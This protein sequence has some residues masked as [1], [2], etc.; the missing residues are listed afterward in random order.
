MKAGV[1]YWED[2]TVNGVEDEKGDLIPCRDGE[3]WCPEIDIETGQIRNWKTGTVADIHYKVY[4]DGEYWI[5]DAEGKTVLKKEGY[6]PVRRLH[7]H[8]S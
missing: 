5:V 2:S 8:G 3:Y 7:N 4:D 6:V 1:R